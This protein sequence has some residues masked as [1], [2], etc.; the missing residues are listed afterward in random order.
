MGGCSLDIC[1]MVSVSPSSSS[2]S[3]GRLGSTGFA[4]SRLSD[5]TM[6]V[7]ML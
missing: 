6:L 5:G 2:P 4:L 3:V 7:S 1:V